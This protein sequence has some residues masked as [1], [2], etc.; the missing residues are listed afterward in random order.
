[1]NAY[2]RSKESFYDYEGFVEKFKPKKTTDDCY[3]PENIY[4]VIADWAAQE[5][6]LD[7]KNFVRPFWPG[8]DYE[9]FDYP[10]NCVVVD[11][12]PFSIVL[13]IIEYY[14]MRGI[15]FFLFYPSEAASALSR[16]GVCLLTTG[17][18]ITYENGAQ[19]R[20]SF[21]TNME[22]EYVVRTAPDL[23]ALLARE[24]KRNAKTRGGSRISMCIPRTFLLHQWVIISASTELITGS[25]AAKVSI[26][27]G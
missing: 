2:G 4:N 7:R 8:G 21:L 13:K 12:P 24:I 15:K 9:S 6:G 11:N 23:Q 16:D 26:S 20:T 19:V 14:M 17:S 25:S 3:T 1:M 18:R 27:P 10:E 5:Y 22:S